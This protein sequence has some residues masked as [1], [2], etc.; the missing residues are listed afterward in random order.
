MWIPLFPDFCLEPMPQ[1]L[2]EP[3][4]RPDVSR[5]TPSSESGSSSALSL[6]SRSTIPNSS[7]RGEFAPG[8]KYTDHE[9]DLVFQLRADGLSGNQIAKIMEMPRSTVYAILKGDLR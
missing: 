8:A 4:K 6:A 1:P 2:S 3:R 5:Q 9:V 7:A